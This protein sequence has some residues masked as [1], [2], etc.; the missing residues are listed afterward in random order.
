MSWYFKYACNF[1]IKQE[2]FPPP[3]HQA[4][5]PGYN[6]T[7]S[8][9]NWTSNPPLNLIPLNKLFS[10]GDRHLCSGGKKMFLTIR[11]H[12]CLS[13]LCNP[14]MYTSLPTPPPIQVTTQLNQN[15]LSW[16]ASSQQTSWST[17]T[18]VQLCSCYTV[19]TRMYK[20]FQLWPL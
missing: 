13:I 20:V 14:I 4:C 11:A 19:S 2:L 10:S 8:K 17:F 7:R 5:V 6:H 3:P 16:N 9:Q 18:P 12:L 1:L 15:L